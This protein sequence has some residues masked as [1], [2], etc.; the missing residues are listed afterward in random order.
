MSSWL[1]RKTTTQWC[2]PSPRW[3]QPPSEVSETTPMQV[4]QTGPGD[5]VGKGAENEE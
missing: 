3:P 4:L 1:E 5:P 2:L